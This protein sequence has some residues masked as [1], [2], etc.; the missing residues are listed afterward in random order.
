MGQRIPLMGARRQQIPGRDPRPES[1]RPDAFPV[2]GSRKPSGH[3]RG[4]TLF[5]APTKVRSRLVIG[6]SRLARSA[7]CR[8]RVGRRSRT[9]SIGRPA[10]HLA[11]ASEIPVW[12]QLTRSAIH[13]ASLRRY[14]GRNR[15]PP[16]GDRATTELYQCVARVPVA[17]T[18]DQVPPDLRTT[19]KRESCS[20]ASAKSG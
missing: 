6:V 19:R 18:R 17:K 15:Y 9:K 2:S 7:P 4:H 8:P 13:A 12:R 10:E 3:L 1:W 14:V 20:F 16:H 11:A 5:G